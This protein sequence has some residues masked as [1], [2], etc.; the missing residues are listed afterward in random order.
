MFC[1]AV[2]RSSVLIGSEWSISPYC[3]RL[4][5]WHQGYRK[6]IPN[7][8]W[9]PITTKLETWHV[10]IPV[11]GCANYPC[12]LGVS[13]TI[14]ECQTNFISDKWQTQSYKNVNNTCR[15]LS[16]MKIIL[17]ARKMAAIL[18]IHS[19]S[20]LPPMARHF[21]IYSSNHDVFSGSQY[22]VRGYFTCYSYLLSPSST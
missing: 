16:W 19:P 9:K 13:G 12:L 3:L 8:D 15:L 4:L 10:T 1:F 22:V 2:V 7:I 21:R 5:N 11:L 18:T 6:I 20:L 17:Q 14:S